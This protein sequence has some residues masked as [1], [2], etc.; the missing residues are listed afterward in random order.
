[1]PSIFEPFFTTKPIGVG[2]GLGLSSAQLIV[3]E[4]DGHIKV[5][6]APGVGTKFS[7]YLPVLRA[8]DAEGDRRKDNI[9]PAQQANEKKAA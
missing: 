5:E 1:L 9:R 3:R 4:H 6:S 8:F 7:I 2:A